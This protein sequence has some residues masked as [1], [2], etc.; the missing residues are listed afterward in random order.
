MYKSVI[1]HVFLSL[2]ITSIENVVT[3]FIPDS[4]FLTSLLPLEPKVLPNNAVPICPGCENSF[5]TVDLT[6]KIIQSR[7]FK[8]LPISPH[9]SPCEDNTKILADLIGG[10][11]TKFGNCGKVKEFF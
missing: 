3:N 4:S 6:N 2:H 1:F 9:L 11:G 8:I 5:L 7:F 10:C